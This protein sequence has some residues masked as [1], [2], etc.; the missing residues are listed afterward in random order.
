MRVFSLPDLLAD[1]ARAG[2]HDVQV[3]DAPCFEFGIWHDIPL[4]LP[5]IARRAPAHARVLAFGPHAL[6]RGAAAPP[7][8]WLRLDRE[9]I[10]VPYEIWVG[11]YHVEAVALPG[12]VEF[13]I[14]AALADTA[15]DHPIVIR[16]PGSGPAIAAGSLCVV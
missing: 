8:A 1:L 10:A 6:V 15:G 9:A 12:L 3:L 11:G 14:P 4:S 2:F 5:M 16:T 7:D 13:A